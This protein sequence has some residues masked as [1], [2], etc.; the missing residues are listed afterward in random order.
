MSQPQDA[1]LDQIQKNVPFFSFSDYF[2]YI[3]EQFI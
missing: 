1:H 3:F 2:E